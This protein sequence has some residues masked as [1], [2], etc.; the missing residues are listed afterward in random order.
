V[1]FAR[2]E[3]LF[4]LLPVIDA[5]IARHLEI[6]GRGKENPFPTEAAQLPRLVID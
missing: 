5:A 4:Y 3:E 1:A 6:M 2:K